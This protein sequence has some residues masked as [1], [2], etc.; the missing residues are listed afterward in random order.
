MRLLRSILYRLYAIYDKACPLRY[1]IQKIRLYYAKNVICRSGSRFANTVFEGD[2]L[3][4]KRSLLVDSICLG[5]AILP[6]I[7]DFLALGLVNFAVLGLVYIRDSVIIQRT[8]SCQ[9]FLLFI[10]ILVKYLATRIT[11]DY[12]LDLKCI[13]KLPRDI[14]LISDMMCG[15]GLM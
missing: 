12:S 14:W 13:G 4:H 15:S 10:K 6:S 5:I 3:V 9:P 1:F 8:L 2:N 11:L 7:A